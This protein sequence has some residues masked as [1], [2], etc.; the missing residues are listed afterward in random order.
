M[1]IRHADAIIMPVYWYFHCDFQ[2]NMALFCAT[3]FVLLLLFAEASC[4]IQLRSENWFFSE[5][6]HCSL[7]E[8]TVDS[9]RDR[10]LSYPKPTGGLRDRR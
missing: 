8:I 3:D 10:S 1:H 7:R 9:G 5:T 2:Q 6:G 4:L